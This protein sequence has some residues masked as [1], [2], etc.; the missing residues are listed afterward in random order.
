MTYDI[1]KK[2]SRAELIKFLSQHNVQLPNISDEEFLAQIRIL[3]LK[4][5]E[6]NLRKMD[7]AVTKK[8]VE[9]Q[10]QPIE[11][12]RLMIDS[13]KI[14]KEIAKTNIKINELEHPD[15]DPSIARE[16]T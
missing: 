15:S 10:D 4:Q 6:M 2:A 5:H 16:G 3:R 13:D 8:M 1:L 9:A 14:N 7:A 11:Y 12:M